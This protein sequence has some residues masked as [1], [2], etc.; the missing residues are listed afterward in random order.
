MEIYLVAHQIVWFHGDAIDFA[1]HA[2]THQ[3]LTKSTSRIGKFVVSEK[4]QLDISRNCD[5]H[6]SHF[7]TAGFHILN[8][9]SNSLV[10]VGFCDCCG[11]GRS[12]TFVFQDCN[13]VTLRVSCLEI[14]LSAFK[15][16]CN[17]VVRNCLGFVS[18]NE[19]INAVVLI[20][21]HVDIFG[22]GLS[23]FN[24]ILTS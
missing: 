5:A 18:I 9:F 17:Q 7:H 1:N 10:G 4:C 14:H 11:V 21:W 20:H 6:V 23:K 16:L 15:A 12:C 13:S 3:G 24:A 22:C 8:L 19:L 2:L